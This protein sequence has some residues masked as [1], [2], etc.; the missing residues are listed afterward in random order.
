MYR[1]IGRT[2][3]IFGNDPC[4]CD[5]LCDTSVDINTLPTSLAEGTGGKTKYDNQLCSAGS[6][7]YITS[8]NESYILNNQDNW[9][10]QLSNNENMDDNKYATLMPKPYGITEYFDY[11]Y[12][13]DVDKKTWGSICGNKIITNKNFNKNNEYLSL[14]DE[15]ICAYNEDV[16]AHSIYSIIQTSQLISGWHTLIGA[17]GSPPQFNL[18]SHDGY[19]AIGAGT[20][21]GAYTSTVKSY[22]EWHVCCI[23]L[24][25]SYGTFY[26]DGDKIYNY[27][28]Y[29]TPQF[30]GVNNQLKIGYIYDNI[31]MIAI[32]KAAHGM[33]TVYENSMYLKSKYNI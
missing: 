13:V 16:Y 26:I 21:N 8:E 18:C 17:F 5:F 22:N 23:T 24:N 15:F 2:G 25:N 12:N 1:V 3:S 32:C 20:S 4:V 9:I 29:N 30:G 10:K 33:N 6:K 19:L 14:N 27:E 7:A 28:E 11:Q 31:K